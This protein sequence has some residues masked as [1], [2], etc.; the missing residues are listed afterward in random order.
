MAHFAVMFRF[1]DRKLGPSGSIIRLE[2][3]SQPVAIA[4]ATRQYWKTLTRKERFDAGSKM[5]VTC[6]RYEGGEDQ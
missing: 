4:K 1:D 2:A 3:T 5:I 6:I